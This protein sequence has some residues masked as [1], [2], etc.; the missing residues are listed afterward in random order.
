M[1]TRS[2]IRREVLTGALSK[3]AAIAKYKWPACLLETLQFDSRSLE[4]T[5]SL[6]DGLLTLSH[7]EGPSALRGYLNTSTVCNRFTAYGHS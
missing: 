4:G 1:E 2:E 6:R 5:V 3:R 7:S